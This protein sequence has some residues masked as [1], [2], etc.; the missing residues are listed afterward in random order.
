MNITLTNQH[1][2][3]TPCTYAQFLEMYGAEIGDERRRQICE[4]LLPSDGQFRFTCPQGDL[5]L[6]R[7][8]IG[9]PAFLAFRVKHETAL[10]DLRSYALDSQIDADRLNPIL[11]ARDMAAMIAAA[12][13]LTQYLANSIFIDEL[14][15]ALIGMA[16]RADNSAGLSQTDFPTCKLRP[17]TVESGE[18][19]RPVFMLVYQ[20]GIANLFRVASANLADFGRDAQRV[21]QGDFRTAEHMA[22]GAGLAG[23][24]VHSVACNQAGDVAKARWNGDLLGQ[25]FSREFHP[26][27]YTVGQ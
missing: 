24:V 6:K 26:V 25:P 27:F 10:S 21:F 23:A 9:L 8:V 11:H 12:P 20:G 2:Q 17:L 22:H 7:A 15:D 1:G 18:V 13:N 4:A 5:L 19:I 14:Y 16:A 3:V